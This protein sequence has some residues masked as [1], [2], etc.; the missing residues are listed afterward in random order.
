MCV[1]SGVMAAVRHHRRGVGPPST[2]RP[3]LLPAAC[4][5]SM[6]AAEPRCRVSLLLLPK[7]KREEDEDGG[8]EEAGGRLQEGARRG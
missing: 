1:D 5:A 8:G 4:D 2:G 7:G 3:L 6:G